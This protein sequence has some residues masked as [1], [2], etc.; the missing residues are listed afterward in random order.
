MLYFAS[1]GSVPSDAGE[2]PF[3]ANPLPLRVAAESCASS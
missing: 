3:C 1:I 2:Q